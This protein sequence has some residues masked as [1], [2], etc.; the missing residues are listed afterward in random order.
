MSTS[1]LNY[2]GNIAQQSKSLVEDFAE[3]V[4]SKFHK[5]YSTLGEIDEEVVK[6]LKESFNEVFKSWFATEFDENI[7][8]QEFAKKTT[9]KRKTGSTKTRGKMKYSLMDLINN[10]C[11]K[12]GKWLRLKR[13]DIDEQ[14]TLTKDGKFEHGGN[15][16]KSG[17][18]LIKHFGCKGRWS[19][20]VYYQ[21]IPLLKLF[22]GEVVEYGT[23]EHMEQMGWK[24]V[25][26]PKKT[27][28]KKVVKPPAKK[29]VKA[30][31]KKAVKPPAK[32]AVKAPA[33]KAP[34][35][36]KAPPRKTAAEKKAEAREAQ[37]KEAEGQGDLFA[38][39]SRLDDKPKG[40]PL[41][42]AVEKAT[43]SSLEADVADL[44]I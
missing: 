39:G 36:K 10:G 26:Q 25:E 3:E 1:S 5:N 18:A 28:A 33:K 11:I 2:I 43:E 40:E 4:I 17:T 24:K 20:M 41:K 15:T 13:N 34:A 29:A 19:Q 9:K 30:P 32:K 27:P 21:S 35:K 44:G 31:A 38:S 7:I 12:T 14:I 8:T 6:Q 16:F 37:A 42:T 23:E 22:T